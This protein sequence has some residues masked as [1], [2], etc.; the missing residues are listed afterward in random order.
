MP[1]PKTQKVGTIMH[2]LK[3]GRK[4][5]YVQRVAIALAHARKMG[6]DIPRKMAVSKLSRKAYKR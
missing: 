1:L 3:K 4:R 6:A 2:E 5:P